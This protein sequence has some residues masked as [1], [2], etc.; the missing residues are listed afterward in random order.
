MTSAE[1]AELGTA[2]ISAHKAIAKRTILQ[3]LGCP[4]PCTLIITNNTMAKGILKSRI[5]PKQTKAM[6]MDFHWVRDCKA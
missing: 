2:H 4:Q 6:D 5:Q 3:E 1:D